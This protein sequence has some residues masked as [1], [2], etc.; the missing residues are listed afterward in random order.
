[1]GKIMPQ[2]IEVWYLIPA[3]RREL[4]MI[5]IKDYRLNQKKAAEILGITE[6]AISQYLNAKRGNEIKFSKD[7]T[8]KIKKTA[9]EILRDEKNVMKKIYNLSLSLRK[10]KALC[11]IHRS[12]DRSIS[13]R[14]DIC[15][16]V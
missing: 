16:Q 5:F 14:C 8:E 11:E 15:F 3:L 2:E 12:H 7:E 1:M 9:M 4:T 13:K 6:A 10:S